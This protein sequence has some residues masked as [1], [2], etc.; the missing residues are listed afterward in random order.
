MRNERRLRDRPARRLRSAP[1]RRP[2]RPPGGASAGGG[3]GRAPRGTARP[4]PAPW[5]ARGGRRSAG[6]SAPAEGRPVHGGDRCRP[7]HRATR[8]PLRPGSRTPRRPSPLR[9]AARNRRCAE[10]NRRCADPNR[11]HPPHP[12]RR[13]PP[14][15]TDPLR[16]RARRPHACRRQRARRY[17]GHH[18]ACC[19]H[20]ARPRERHPAA[21]IRCAP[22]AVPAYAP[23]NPGR[24]PSTGRNPRMP[25]A[26]WRRGGTRRHWWIN[27]CP[28]VNR[29]AS[30]R[31]PP[32]GS[33][34]SAA[35]RREPDRRLN[36]IEGPSATAHTVVRT[37]SIRRRLRP[38]AQV[39]PIGPGRRPPIRSRLHPKRP[40]ALVCWRIDD[41]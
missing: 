5:P 6:T 4:N 13:S 39:R 12:T 24:P 3:P 41:N 30:R 37:A 15:R 27:P 25:R 35:R 26:R 23:P 20:H 28:E 7:D 33:G 1:G 9:C 36:S 34:F 2:R 38:R 16:R 11:A 18:H 32:C 8:R 10:R 40:D 14:R 29:G 31:D 17:R 22:R 19:H 21:P